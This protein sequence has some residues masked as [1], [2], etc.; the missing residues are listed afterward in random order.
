ML[1]I[2]SSRADSH[3]LQGSKLHNVIVGCN[4]YVGEGCDI[5]KTVILGNET[6]TNDSSR[7][8]S[9]KKGETVLGI[10]VTLTCLTTQISTP[11]RRLKKYL[12]QTAIHLRF[13]GFLL[14]MIACKQG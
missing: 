1:C 8:A 12:G 11:R 9:R 13:A 3:M 7:A 10:G 5:S 2:N 14:P 6:Y 4:S